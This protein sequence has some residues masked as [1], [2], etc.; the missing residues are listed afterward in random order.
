MTDNLQTMYDTH[1][2]DVSDLEGQ[3]AEHES[4]INALRQD[5]QRLRNASKTLEGAH[6]RLVADP[7][8]SPNAG[9]DRNSHSV[10]PRGGELHDAEA[11]LRSVRAERDELFLRLDEQTEETSALQEERDTEKRSFFSQDSTIE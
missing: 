8:R 1:A 7:T 6:Q 2:T 4:Q 9:T 5:N 10:S 3:L 11:L